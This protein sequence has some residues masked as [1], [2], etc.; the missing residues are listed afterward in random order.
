MKYAGTMFVDQITVD[1][2]ER[3]CREP[4]A[5]VKG[6]GTEFDRE[7]RFSNG[8]VMAIQVCPSNTPSEE[9]CWTQGVLFTP[10]GSEVGCTD[11]GEAFLG[12]YNIAYSDDEYEVDVAVD[13][14]A[15]NQA[16]T[17]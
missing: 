11:V 3:I 4:D 7:Y 5:T 2:M 13:P 8:M 12:E 9:S 17:R 14:N 10:D 15:E 1:D 16:L 6:K